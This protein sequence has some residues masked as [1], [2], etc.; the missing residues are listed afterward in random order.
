MSVIVVFVII[1][2]VLVVMVVVIM[3]VSYHIISFV[4]IPWILT[5]LQ[6]PYGYGS[7]RIC[8][9]SQEVMSV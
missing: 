5:G 9:S 7:S 1:I 3:F 6:N 8:L 2:V 4:F